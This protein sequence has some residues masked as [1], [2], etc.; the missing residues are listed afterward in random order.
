M[1]EIQDTPDEGSLQGER[2]ENE[3]CLVS[4]RTTAIP[5]T[6][7]W[8]MINRCRCGEPRGEGIRDHTPPSLITQPGPQLTGG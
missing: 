4:V 2:K 6:H 7:P 8:A 5:G 3:D 1:A